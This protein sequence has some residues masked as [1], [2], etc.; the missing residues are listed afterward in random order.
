MLYR[1]I[2]AVCSQIHTKHINALCGQNAAFPTLKANGAYLKNTYFF[3]KRRLMLNAVVVPVRT[4]TMLAGMNVRSGRTLHVW[5]V[6]VTEATQWCE[7][8]KHCLY[9]LLI[10]QHVSTGT[11]IYTVMFDGD[12]PTVCN[13]RTTFCGRA[14]VKLL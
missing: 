10:Q 4:D 14:L 7:Q 12:V 1:E 13:V 9:W 5:C 6:F 8:I 2:I 11:Q 3:L